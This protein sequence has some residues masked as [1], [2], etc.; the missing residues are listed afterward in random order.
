MYEVIDGQKVNTVTG[1]VE[2]YT[3]SSIT[4]MTTEDKRFY[5]YT[6][7]APESAVNKDQVLDYIKACCDKRKLVTYSGTK[8]IHDAD[9]GDVKRTGRKALFT[10]PQYK[11]MNK[12]I[13]A[14]V[15]R[16]IVI[17]SKTE[18]AKALGVEPK[19]LTN[20]LATLS[21]LIVVQTEGMTKGQIKILI[22]PAY[23]FK[24]ESSTINS[25]RQSAELKWIK[26]DSETAEETQRRLSLPN[27]VI[28]QYDVVFSKE[29][30]SFLN[31]MSNRAAKKRSHQ[32]KELGIDNQYVAPSEEQKFIDDYNN[33]TQHSLYSR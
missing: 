31:G 7:V 2:M 17:G 10:V 11:M 18:I 14:L 26:K 8:S 25:A 29:F 24:Y 21:N 6:G 12:L 19:N 9:C 1:E 28:E 30:D 5:K 27:G 4:P 33:G 32:L 15:Y 22:H 20:T 3:A 16:N 23:G 13:K